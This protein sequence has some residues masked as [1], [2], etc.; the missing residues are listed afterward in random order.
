MDRRTNRPEGSGV[1]SPTVVTSR[2]NGE[3]LDVEDDLE[4]RPSDIVSAAA[5]GDCPRPARPQCRTATGPTIRRTGLSRRATRRSSEPGTDGL[6]DGASPGEL[7]A[8]GSAGER[9]RRRGG[10][11]HRRRRARPAR[12]QSRGR[13]AARGPRIPARTRAPASPLADDSPTFSFD[14][15][16]AAP[17]SPGT[18]D[19]TASPPAE[20]SAEDSSWMT[21]SSSPSSRP[22]LSGAEPGPAVSPAAFAWEMPDPPASSPSSPARSFLRGE[23]D[24]K[25]AAAAVGCGSRPWP[26]TQR[27]T[28]PR[29]RPVRVQPCRR[30]DPGSRPNARH[31]RPT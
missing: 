24:T 14:R 5:E 11:H 18:D 9:L 15:P 16:E 17:L 1:A 31:G 4:T 26:R 12:R 7:T 29:P 2:P 27:D 8:D 23:T 25:M 30:A 3:D 10:C 21:P 6:A 28:R 20:S 19:R 13:H 22:G